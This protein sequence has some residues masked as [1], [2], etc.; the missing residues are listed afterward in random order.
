MS[1]VPTVDHSVVERNLTGANDRVQLSLYPIEFAPS[2][3]SENSKKGEKLE[4]TKKC[5]KSEKTKN[6]AEGNSS[7]QTTEGHRS[8]QTILPPPPN[9]VHAKTGPRF[10]C[11]VNIGTQ[12][13]NLLLDSGATGD[14]ID[15]DFAEKLGLVKHPLTVPGFT[16]IAA[17]KLRQPITHEVLLTL[18][19]NDL[20]MTRGFYVFPGLNEHLILG[21]P[22]VV[23]YEQ[24]ISW[25]KSQFNGKP[26]MDESA[27]AENG[28]LEAKSLQLEKTDDGLS[29]DAHFAEE[30]DLV[31]AER[32][33][34]NLNNEVYAI[35]VRPC[36]KEELT[37]ELTVESIEFANGAKPNC[38]DPTIFD[39]A[40]FLDV[41]RDELPTELP[42]N[43][44]IKHR[45]DLIPGSSP[46]HQAPYRLYNKELLELEKMMTELEEAGKIVPHGSAYG[47]PIILV[48]KPDGSKRLCVDYRALNE[49]TIR[50]RFPIPLI[51]SIFDALA[52]AKV[53]SS[54]DLHS[55]YHQIRMAEEDVHKTAFV[56]PFGQYVW[57]VMPFGLTNAPSTFQ[58]MMNEVFAKFLHKFVVVYLDDILIYSK[59]QEEHR[60]HVKQ[61]LT[62]LREHELIAK[63]KK[64]FFFQ[65]HLKFLGHA[66]S[67]EGIKPDPGKLAAVQEWKEIRTV[68]QAQ[69]FLGLANYYRRFIPDYSKYAACIH[70]FVAK[71]CKWGEKQQQMFEKIKELLVSPPLLIL[72]NPNDTFVLF[73]DASYYCLGS[74]LHQVGLDNKLKGVVAYESRKLS[75]AELNWDVREKELFSIIH[76][77]KKWKHYLADKRFIL[78][79]DH[80]S[81]QFMLKQKR[82]N[83]RII[84]WID[85]FANFDIDIRYIQGPKN[86]VADC[87]SRKDS[88][89]AEAMEE[90]EVESRAGDSSPELS[91]SAVT[92]ARSTISHDPAT[93]AQLKTEYKTDGIFGPIYKQLTSA[94]PIPPALESKLRRYS[95]IEGLLYYA[96]TSRDEL[97]LCIPHGTIRQAVLS[98]AH[99]SAAAGHRGVEKTY[100]LL[101]REYYWKNMLKTC[102]QYVNACDACQ[103]TKSSSQAT[104][105]MLA[106]LPIPSER[107]EEITMD[108]VSGFQQ[109]RGTG[110]DRILVVVDRL[111]KMAHFIPTIKELHS[112]YC[113]ELLLKHIFRL[114]GVPKVIVSDRDVLFSNAHWKGLMTSWKV[115]TRFTTKEH[116]E[117][118]GQSERTIRTVQNI[119]R[120]LL[121]DFC[122]Q[123]DSWDY[124][125]PMVEFAYNNAYQSS[126]GCS[127]FYANY[128]RHPRISHMLPSASQY[129]H[130]SRLEEGEFVDAQKRVLRDIR[131]KMAETQDRMSAQVNK[132]RR[133]VSYKVGDQVLVARRLF[134]PANASQ[135]K[136]HPLFVGPFKVSAVV[137]Q[138]A[139]QI[140][141]PPAFKSARRPTQVFNTT[142]LKP[143]ITGDPNIEWIPPHNV[144]DIAA[145]SENIGRLESHGSTLLRLSWKNLTQTLN[146]S[147]EDYRQLPI[148]TRRRIEREYN[149]RCPHR[150]Y[151]STQSRSSMEQ[152]VPGATESTISRH[153]EMRAIPEMR[154]RVDY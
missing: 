135:R 89:L 51:D 71:K 42:P 79:T 129:R 137:N 82:P 34:K 19:F 151:Q 43:R 98:I 53:F 114:H 101:A 77:L 31:D 131:E 121:Q 37:H 109:A 1:K 90:V 116:P 140:D 84:R 64:C 76:S 124:F 62:L 55:G 95:V 30:M 141:L 91:I 14:F 61:V 50:E 47:A 138:N 32:E 63:A 149:E 7:E 136:F 73:T 97:C 8:N 29:T 23:D 146:L 17:T 26:C 66:L 127:P 5:E 58:R 22:F 27:Q 41:I 117:T 105:G 40:E 67:A 147:H 143:Y 152:R 96:I 134:D 115:S 80:H 21:S 52:G 113:M 49:I 33:C 69:S 128:G 93:L 38:V 70:D 45:I 56:T 65:T 133:A 25:A 110:F 125:L 132:H 150:P 46:P 78:Y 81:L 39:L 153:R 3:N 122:Q 88:D 108:F 145:A 103:R 15:E 59:N 87:L 9:H 57:R 120:P 16:K 126:I 13:V 104:A 4:K 48:K 11:R 118:D 60:Q 28:F 44:R 148:R 139:Y 94:D 86:V 99:D 6:K 2:E 106:P 72:P 144:E 112:D 74:V 83:D 130:G 107:W 102:R 75:G 100:D 36:P 20:S 119:I 68:K 85:L 12:G 123:Y 18:T 24:Y 154:R 35:L 92:F 54:L 111:T 142:S 10:L